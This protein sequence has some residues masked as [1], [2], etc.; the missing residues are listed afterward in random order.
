MSAD[1]RVNSDE[2]AG[3]AGNS[4]Q[5]AAEP[6]R[7][8][9]RRPAFGIVASMFLGVAAFLVTSSIGRPGPDPGAA[10]TNLVVLPI[11]L[12]LPAIALGA[13]MV[14]WH[15]F[16]QTHGRLRLLLMVPTAIAIILNAI[17]IAAFARWVVRVLQP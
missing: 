5:E 12:L 2:V 9:L 17:A 15:A 6:R 16:G 13:A 11:A 3:M 7:W 8:W 4:D 1:P 10:F 14:A